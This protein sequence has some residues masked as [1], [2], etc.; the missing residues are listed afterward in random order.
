M[1]LRRIGVLFVKDVLY[2]SRNIIFVMAIVLPLALSLVIGLLFGT[3]FSE[4]PRLGIADGGTSQ[5]AADLLAADFMLVQQYDSEDALLAALETGAVEIGLSLPTNL[6]ADLRSGARTDLMVYV[7][8]QSLVKNRVI[9]MSAVTEALVDLTGRDM[10]VTIDAVLVGD[11]AALSWQQ[12]LLPL[13]VL[14]SVMVGGIMV[15]ATSM[16]EEKQGRTLRALTV[17]PMTMGEVLFTKGLMGVL[18]SVFSGV[19]ILT[20]NGG[21]GPNPALLLAVL[22]LGGGLA[23][24][25]GVLL[26]SRVKDIQILFAIIK[27]MGI[28]LYAPGIIALFPDSIPQWIAR[29]FPTYYVMQPV[30][31]VS[32]RGAGLGD[33]AFDLTILVAI[34]TVLIVGLGITADRLQVQEA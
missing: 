10:P 5:L 26:G 1:S 2:G 33:I 16:V 20:L 27:A 12:R 22:A 11:R 24:S 34:I 7:W 31:D 4:K 8:G 21:W 6:E 9:I 18:L 32:Q 3:L 14:M 28:L 13:V 15:P 19:A 30:M 29:L 25:F 17:T 23:A